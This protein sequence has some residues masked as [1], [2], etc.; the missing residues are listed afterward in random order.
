[1]RILALDDKEKGT[2]IVI[3]V[4]VALY[5]VECDGILFFEPDGSEWYIPNVSIS[6]HN[7]V[8]REL[9][10]NEYCDVTRFGEITYVEE[11]M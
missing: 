10:M 7:Y 11:D 3:E 5:D 6:D 9:M 2:N 8:C 4:E 1:M